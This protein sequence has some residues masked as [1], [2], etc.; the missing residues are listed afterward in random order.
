MKVIAFPNHKGGVGKTTL[1][2]H[3][4]FYG[5]EKNLRVLA[6]DF[7]TQGN[8][9]KTCMLQRQAHFGE[10]KLPKAIEASQLFKDKPGAAQPLDCGAGLGLIA[11]D[12]KLQDGT[13]FSQIHNPRNAL[14]AFAKDYDLCVIDTMPTPGNALMGALIAADYLVTPC[15][16]GQDAIDGLAELWDTISRLRELGWNAELDMIGLLPNRIRRDRAQDLSN[17][18]VLRNALGDGVLETVLYERSA[19]QTATDKPVW[20]TTRGE[21]A[22]IAAKEM[23]AACSLIFNRMGLGL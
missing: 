8:F 19:T 11:A 15:E 13:K 20:R 14:Q 7:E 18:E 1:A 4:M 10:T 6:V 3:I 9:S 23:R 16:M 17:L 12:N 5:L 22:S 2:R 21:S